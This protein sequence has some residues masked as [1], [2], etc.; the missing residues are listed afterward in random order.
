MLRPRIPRR[1]RL[2][3]ALAATSA[4]A[5][6]G[7]VSSPATRRPRPAAASTTPSP[8]S[9]RAAS[10]PPSTSP[11]SA[12]RSTA[13]PCAGR[14]PAGQTVTQLWNGAVTQSGAQV[15]RHGRRLQRRR[16]PPA[17][18]ASFGF[19]GSVDRQQPGAGVVRAQRR[20]V[21]RRRAV[22]PAIDVRRP[23][24]PPIHR[25]RR[26]AAP[27]PSPSTVDPPAGQRAG[28]LERLNRGLISVRSGS[29][30][31]VSWRLAGHR[32]GDGRLQR[33]PG[34]TKV[35][36]SPITGSTNY[37]D[38][39][40][41]AG[42][43]YTVRA[44]VNGAE[45]AGVG[46]GAAVRATATSTCRS[47]TPTAPCYAANDAS[48]GD[49]DGDGQLE[50]VLKWD[51]P[52]AKDNSQS[53]VTE[54]RLRRRVPAQRHPAVAD[55]PGPQHPRRRALHA[56]PGLR[57]RRR[58]QG[59]GRDEDGRR[60]RL[61]HRTGHRQR[62]RRLPQLLRLHPVSGPEYLT[63][64]NG[65]TGAAMS[66]V[67]YVPPRG[68]VSSLG[69]QLR[70]PRRPV[71][72]RHRVPG[73]AARPSLIMAR[74]YYTRTVIVAWDFRNGALTRRWTF[75]SNVRRQRST[76]GRA[77]TSCPSPTSTATAGTRSSTARWPS[78]TT[79][80]PLWNTGNGHGDALHVGDLD[81]AAD[82]GLEV[83]K[84]DEDGTKPVVVDGRR[85]YRADPVDAPAATATTAAASPTTS[86][87]AAPAP[88]R[89][90]AADDSLRN[91]ER[92]VAGPQA[93]ARR[94]S[95]PGGTATRSANCSTAPT[96]TSTAPPATPAC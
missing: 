37:L 2:L 43:A 17:R 88:S 8:T 16:S 22:E 21:H 18:T 50:I 69:R 31:L 64:F 78:T 56:V 81:P 76:P 46:G 15:S 1:H 72:G 36:A 79:A 83:F 5:L 12:T 70:Q 28:R 74:G 26:V 27:S 66:T 86:G 53:G 49:L 4:A 6:A 63:M 58:R 30:N 38:S 96:S 33:L 71:P 39:G 77:T 47:R 11:T 93:R 55:Q 52:N 24:R 14:S 48:V 29:G 40:A 35:N 20:G 67:N 61:R 95:W 94:T 85:A 51:P 59:R 9:G 92:R 68:T 84:V 57:L 44:V 60:H 82:P 45:Q 3:A 25:H 32:P 65:Q 62:L 23:P 75:D 7:G 41:A 80:Q 10:A 89:G 19:N 34:R 42:A 54:Q 13:G 90:R 87:P 73:R 91:A